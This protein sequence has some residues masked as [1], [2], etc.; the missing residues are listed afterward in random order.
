MPRLPHRGDVWRGWRDDR[1]GAQSIAV[2]VVED[3]GDNNGAVRATSIGA[4]GIP[5]ASRGPA[6]A[7]CLLGG[8]GIG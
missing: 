4:G 1:N 7:F 8:F 3:K 6:I 2:C 5:R